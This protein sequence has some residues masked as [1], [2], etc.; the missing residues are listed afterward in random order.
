MSKETTARSSAELEQGDQYH[1]PDD[2]ASEKSGIATPFDQ[3]LE[4][5]TQ[6]TNRQE[7]A[8]DP[9]VVDWDG[10][11]DPENPMNWPQY[12][13]VINIGLISLFTFL[14]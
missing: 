13:K 14:T 2:T 9:D 10:P 3:D 12:R 8:P 1:H 4:T 5:G 7:D 6:T 11:D